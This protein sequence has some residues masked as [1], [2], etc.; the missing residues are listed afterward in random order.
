MAIAGAKRNAYWQTP[1]R[2]LL[3]HFLFFASAKRTHRFRHM[4]GVTGARKLRR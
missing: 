2:G 1:L 4:P 3:R